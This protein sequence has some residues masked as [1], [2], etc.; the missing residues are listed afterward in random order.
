MIVIIA[1][2]H[3]IPEKL[4]EF[5]FYAAEMVHKTRQEPG[6]LSYELLEDAEDPCHLTYLERW[7]D[8]SAVMRHNASEHFLRLVPL[9]AELCEK[10]GT[11][12]M[13]SP[14]DLEY[15]EG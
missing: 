5:K 4:D 8:D 10:R 2:K 7:E 9:T 14:L 15:D 12:T 3:V 13:C 1:E 6:C 11:V